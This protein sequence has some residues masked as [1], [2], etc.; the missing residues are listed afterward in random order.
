M[1]LVKRYF[2]N[3]LKRMWEQIAES[4]YPGILMM[5]EKLKT[6]LPSFLQLYGYRIQTFDG[7]YFFAFY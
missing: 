7:S 4:M 3:H 6:G 1:T 2:M 5:S